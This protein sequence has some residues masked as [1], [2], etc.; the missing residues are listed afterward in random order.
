MSFLKE[1]QMAVMSL[2]VDDDE[3]EERVSEEVC[4]RSLR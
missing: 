4:T 2:L 1:C 3:I